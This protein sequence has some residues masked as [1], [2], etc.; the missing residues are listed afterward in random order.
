MK[1]MSPS[2]KW[3][4]RWLAMSL[5]TSL[6][7]FLGGAVVLELV[8]VL[9]RDFAICAL[10]GAEGIFKTAFGVPTSHAIQETET[11]EWIRQVGGSHH[12]HLWSSSCKFRGSWGDSWT[13]VTCG[14]AVE[15]QPVRL[16]FGLNEQLGEDAAFVELVPEFVA[17]D[18]QN[19]A[20]REEIMRAA[21]ELD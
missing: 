2:S 4:A 3:R 1:A 16:L 10:C 20:R 15:A 18:P 11:S 6:G 21:A 12:E 13:S 14:R 7:I 17:R 9:A 8:P 5:G 19:Q